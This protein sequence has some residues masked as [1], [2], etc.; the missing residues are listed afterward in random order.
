MEGSVEEMRNFARFFRNFFG[1]QNNCAKSVVMQFGLL[2]GI[3]GLGNIDWEYTYAVFG[4]AIDIEE[5][6]D[7]RL[8]AC[9]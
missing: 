4:A 2:C 6:I 7:C 9:C 3:L 8:A 5:D 1:H